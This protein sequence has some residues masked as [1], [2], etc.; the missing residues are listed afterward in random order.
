MLTKEEKFKILF[1][2][3]ILW[4]ALCATNFIYAFVL[5]RIQQPGSES[6]P[7]VMQVLLSSP[8]RELALA[9]VCTLIVSR[10]L[11]SF[12]MKT[13]LKQKGPAK[14][15]RDCLNYFFLPFIIGM[16]MLESVS[17]FGF[18]IAT[19]SHQV[20]VYYIFAVICLM[21]QLIRFPREE[22]LLA[23]GG[24]ARDGMISG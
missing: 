20:F 13:L 2:P 16:A 5:L 6:P 12:L 23:A 14:D 21:N 18:V 1:T 17:I 9:A 22:R 19:L 8:G 11:P 7:A 15:L 10:I 24:I 4:G 3:R